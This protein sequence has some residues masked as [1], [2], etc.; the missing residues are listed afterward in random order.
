MSE[1]PLEISESIDMLRLIEIGKKVKM[2]PIDE[3]SF[4]V[5]TEE[6][7]KFVESIMEK[8]DLLNQYMLK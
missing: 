3:Q 6:R 2:V 8:D 4:S 5:D 1:S 7:R